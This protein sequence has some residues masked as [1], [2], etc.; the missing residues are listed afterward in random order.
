[1]TDSW[2]PAHLRRRARTALVVV[3]LI[4][5][6]RAISEG[7]HAGEPGRPSAASAYAGALGPDAPP[8]APSLP[9]A[10]P[11][12]LRIPAIDVDAPLT[13]L[14]RDADNTLLPP[15]PDDANLAGWD[16]G[17]VSP[18]SAGTAVVAGHYDTS[19]G[20]AA[21]YGLHALEPGSEVRVV[22][23]DGRTAVF[24][25]GAVEEYEKEDFPSAKVYRHSA[26][27]ELRLITCG[28]TF[29]DDGG[30][31]ANTV[32]YAYLTGVTRP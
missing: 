23:A 11:T 13:E 20:P 5:G 22:R 3:V 2:I 12:R 26:R 6:G 16:R 31:S 30:Y 14:G 8:P 27:A 25:V 10:A 32:V 19:H 18:G 9:S 29:S 4:A 24:T 21:F 1:M 15:P 17:G 7:G 28:G